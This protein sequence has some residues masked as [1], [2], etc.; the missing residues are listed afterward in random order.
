MKRKQ[1]INK[2]KEKRIYLRLGHF[3]PWRP[4]LFLSAA[5]L[6][7]NP[8]SPPHALVA[9][10]LSAAGT[11]YP[12]FVLSGVPLAAGAT[13][14]ALSPCRRRSGSGGHPITG[15]QQPRQIPNELRGFPAAPSLIIHSREPLPCG[16]PLVSK[17][18]PAESD[19]HHNSLAGSSGNK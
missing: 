10:T 6:A 15:S 13:L 12:A 5:H 19:A 1:K 14:P 7:P 11:H 8:A 2:K 4:M 9:T 17:I 16:A 18:F 3:F